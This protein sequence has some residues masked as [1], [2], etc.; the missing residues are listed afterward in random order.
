MKTVVLASVPHAAHRI[1]RDFINYD[2]DQHACPELRLS[3]GRILMKV[4]KTWF[5]LSSLKAIHFT[6]STGLARSSPWSTFTPLLYS[7]ADLAREYGV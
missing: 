2:Q 5:W 7:G 4:Y 6:M 3:A 1:R